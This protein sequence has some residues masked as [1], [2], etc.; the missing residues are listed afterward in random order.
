MSAVITVGR[1]EVEIHEREAVVAMYMQAVEESGILAVAEAVTVWESTED[2]GAFLVL[3]RYA[4]EAKADESIELLSTSSFMGQLVNLVDTPPDI[5]RYRVAGERG[6]RECDVAVGNILSLSIRQA[7]PGL[8][9]DLDAELAR[10][11]DEIAF[12]DGYLGSLHGRSVAV[13]EEIL[14]IA[15]WENESAFRK[16]V[17][18][19]QLFTVEPYVR[20]R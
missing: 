20:V 19:H 8:G 18:G 6:K 17:P 7:D 1:A 5:R 13:H 11:L 2:Q 9:W 16:S 15:L 14:S 3:H 4:D 10:I 12:I